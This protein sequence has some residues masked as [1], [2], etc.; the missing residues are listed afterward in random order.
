MKRFFIALLTLL[1]MVAL[2]VAS[3]SPS[4]PEAVTDTESDNTA[5]V[6]A[7]SALAGY[8]IVRGDASSQAVTD[9][10][11]KLRRLIEER[12][13][14][15]PVLMT[16]WV[17]RGK[18]PIQAEHEIL[19]G[20]TNRTQS[21]AAYE[22]LNASEQSADYL[23]RADGGHYVIAASDFGADAAVE[24]FMNEFLS[25]S[26]TE[27]IMLHDFPIKSFKIGGAD[28]G[29][30]SI[31]AN[32]D[33]Y[34]AR[35]CDIIYNATGIT[36][37]ISDGSSIAEHEIIVGDP[38][39]D[40]A[41]SGSLDYRL[42]VKD[43][44]L[45]IG[46]KSRA[47]DARAM[48]EFLSVV[49]Y[50][51]ASGAFTEGMNSVIFDSA[52][53]EH[54]AEA[55]PLN[56]GAWCTSGDAFEREEQFAE[57]AEA[58]FTQASIALP[59]DPALTE[60]M[61]E[62]AAI[63][64]IDILWMDGAVYGQ[65]DSDFSACDAYISSPNS[66]GNYLCD[67]PNSSLFPSLAKAYKAYSERTGKLP[68]INLFPMY[69][70]AQQ[71][72]NSTY[73]EHVAQF[74]DTVKP[75]YTSVDVYPL[76]SSGLYDG[77]MRNLDIV[78]S[79]CRDRDVALSV[80]IQS[81]SFAASKRTPSYQDLE[82]QAYCCLSFGAKGIV[83]FTY[84]T[85]YSTA[86]NFLPALIDHDLNKTDRWYFA[87]QLNAELNAVGA[88]M[89]GYVNSGAFSHGCT[90]KTAYLDFDNQYDFTA[91]IKAVECDTPLLFGC[92]EKDG[93][94][95]FTAVSMSDLQSGESLTARIKT[96]APVTLYRNGKAEPTL[97]PDADG[98]ISLTLGVGEGVF[99]EIN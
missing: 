57:L 25:M 52:L 88:E 49:G 38:R 46:G 43:G 39:G 65:F 75:I 4:A 13:G 71:L 90:A 61:L 2:S 77:Y 55:V 99:A 45:Y 51:R 58:N 74:L 89:D 29:A 42:G 44:K 60:K 54:I 18:A 12:T 16:D 10:A 68:F 6:Y 85:P 96:D 86:E 36:L 87:Q 66:W 95:A 69:A 14:V 82:W 73:R 84:M 37:A 80:Y 93:K 27:L 23:L 81:V 28:I 67:E 40:F 91:A 35:L 79:E 22:A 1:S 98:Y 70:N 32:D 31:A 19:I 17:Q 3:C 48:Y 26:K 63:Y 97:T 20:E 11:V 30:F 64:N 9:A 15:K 47:A 50:N 92:F 53:T 56:I 72:G 5:A 33:E 8:V 76:N 41:L 24:A 83:Y 34:A 62:W 94:Y 59:S 21:I 7:D 78:A